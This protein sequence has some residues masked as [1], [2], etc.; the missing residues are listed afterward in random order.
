MTFE[1]IRNSTGLAYP[2][3][4]NMKYNRTAMNSMV[5]ILKTI[6]TEPSKDIVFWTAGS[7]GPIIASYVGSKLKNNFY[8]N[9]IKPK[10]IS[11]HSKTPIYEKSHI[12][13]FIDDFIEDG[14]TFRMVYEA[15][16]KHNVSFDCFCLSKVLYLSNIDFIPRIIIAGSIYDTNYDYYN[17]SQTITL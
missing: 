9:H 16:K 6:Y 3:G 10:G 1:F 5:R 11:S 14:V 17:K 2:I 7:S 13:I 8:I 12:H 4:H 15:A